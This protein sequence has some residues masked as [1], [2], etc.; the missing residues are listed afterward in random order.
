M[1][2]PADICSDAD[3]TIAIREILA[4]IANDGRVAPLSD[5]DD[6]FEAGIVDSFGVLQL[7]AA[8]ETKLGISLPDQELIPQNLWSV[9]AI[10]DMIK[11]LR[12]TSAP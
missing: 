9:A 7:I 5:S 1:P 12:S 10:R 2:A 4:A 8:L 11:R 6:L 3:L